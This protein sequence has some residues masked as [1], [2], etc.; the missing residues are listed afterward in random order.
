MDVGKQIKRKSVPADLSHGA[1]NSPPQAC[2]GRQHGLASTHYPKYVHATSALGCRGASLI[3]V[4]ERE[5]RTQRIPSPPSLAE[6]S[7]QWE[8]SSPVGTFFP[9]QSRV[10]DHINQDVQFLFSL[11][12]HINNPRHKDAEQCPKCS[13]KLSSGQCLM[14]C[15]THFND[16]LLLP[17]GQK[18]LLHPSTKQSSCSRLCFG[19][20]GKLKQSE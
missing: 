10:G 13:K 4:R 8:A 16:K 6:H 7:L 14:C 20:F 9:G 15:W 12:L 5:V 18:Q 1:H 3:Q 19:V 11:I 17:Q 2:A